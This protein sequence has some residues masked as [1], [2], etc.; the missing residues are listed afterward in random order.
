M[1]G[2]AVCVDGD[3]A[4]ADDRYYVASDCPPVPAP[5]AEPAK[6]AG[7]KVGGRD[8]H[9]SAMR[10]ALRESLPSVPVTPAMTLRSERRR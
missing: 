7:S 1:F 6:P 5:T 3:S 9:A 2:G 4:A 8:G 10:R